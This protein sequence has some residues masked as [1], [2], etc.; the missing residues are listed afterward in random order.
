M[1]AGVANALEFFQIFI[2]LLEKA[3]FGIWFHPLSDGPPDV[4]ETSLPV[5]P[6]QLS[7]ATGRSLDTQF[8]TRKDV[9]V[10]T[11]NCGMPVSCV[12]DTT[13]NM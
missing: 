5:L 7:I 3:L 1:S 13:A 11:R 8:H 6:M 10:S 12:L 2:S 4:Q 9:L